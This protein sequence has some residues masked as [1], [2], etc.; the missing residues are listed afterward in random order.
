MTSNAT[1][2]EMFRAA[3]IAAAAVCGLAGTEALGQTAKKRMNPR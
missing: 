3:A 2:R 1:R